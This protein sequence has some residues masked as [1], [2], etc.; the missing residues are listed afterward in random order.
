MK[1]PQGYSKASS[2][3]VCELKKSLYSLKQASR[4]WNSKFTAKL[5]EYGFAQFE[6]DH[7]LFVM[8]T[9][10]VFLILLVYVDDVLVTGSCEKS[11]VVV[12]VSA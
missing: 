12:K 7:C 5:I 4:E 8:R 9:T 2:N 11:I 10:D 1:P 3:Q 6:N